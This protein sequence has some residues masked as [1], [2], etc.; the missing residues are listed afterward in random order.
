MHALCFL[1]FKRESTLLF[2][3]RH[4]L[5]SEVDLKPKVL[6]IIQNSCF[7]PEPV[8]NGGLLPLSHSI[9]VPM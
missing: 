9:C 5:P 8:K 3:N 2:S 7:H 1:N 4:S 6:L